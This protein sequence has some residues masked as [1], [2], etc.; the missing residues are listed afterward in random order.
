VQQAS[1]EV[2]AAQTRVT[3]SGQIRRCGRGGEMQ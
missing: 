2:V 3:G 1:L